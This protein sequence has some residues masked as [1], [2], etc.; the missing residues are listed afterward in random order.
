MRP[1]RL[2]L[3]PLVFL[4]FSCEKPL[5]PPGPVE[6][7][8]GLFI[9]NEGNFTYG[10]A[11]L[12]FWDLERDTVFEDVFFAA[13][14]Y[15]LGDV[16]YSM[17]LVGG[18]AFIVVNNSGKVVVADP[19]GLQVQ[20]TLGG[21]VSPRQILPIDDSTAYVSDL[22]STRLSLLDTRRLELRGELELGAT[23]EAMLLHE[24]FAYVAN[25]S[26]GEW[27]FKVDARAH[28]KVDSLRVARQP[29]SMALDAQ[30]QLW[31]LSDGGFPG[32]PGGKQPS[33]LT[34]VRLS[35]FQVTRTLA[36][37]DPLAS[38]TELRAN[39]R[40]DSL[41]FLLNG[42][43]PGAPGGVFVLPI[44]AEA[45]PTRPLVHSQGRLFYGLAVRPSNSELFVSDA[46]D[47]LQ[48]GWVFR[49]SPDGRLLDSVRVGIIPGAFCFYD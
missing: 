32:M 3:L 48:K 23:S 6:L 34:R 24:G 42:T 29:N 38:A 8:Q 27:L 11:S 31:L 1:E 5:P 7:E 17:A 49:A 33:T 13:N 30:G 22:Y 47:Y 2:L 18:K 4:V 44:E 12:S 16:A 25:W 39:A 9:V 41:F 21:L 10:N 36:W 37:P 19:R 26:F 45:M 40:G 20:K 43:A 46:L 28:R 15:P 35:D 14:G